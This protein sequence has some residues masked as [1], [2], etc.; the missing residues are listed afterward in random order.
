MEIAIISDIHS[1]S[2]A[3]E[4]VLGDIKKRAISR[5]VVLG[6]IFGYYPWA[7]ATYNLLRP[8]LENSYFI[9][10][11]HDQLLLDEHPPVPETSYWQAARRNRDELMQYVPEALAWLGSLPFAADVQVNG[12]TFHLFHGTPADTANGRFYPDTPDGEVFA[13]L[14]GF[15][16]LGHTHYPLLRMG[17][18]SKCIIFNPGSVGQPRDGNP[19]PAWGVFDTE[20]KR[21]SFERSLYD[22]AG[23]AEKLEQMN[24]DKHAIAAIRKK[25]KGPLTGNDKKATDGN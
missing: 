21:F 16:L 14:E 25:H 7:V 6:D 11:N 4:A 5:L 9:K 1:N 10:G 2:F 17:N 8:F 12:D 18:D 24:W 19:D 13:G 22:Y 20:S 15:V 3:L 23:A